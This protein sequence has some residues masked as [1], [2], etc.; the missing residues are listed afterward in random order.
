[1]AVFTKL[2]EKEIKEFISA[3]PLGN[4]DQ[5]IEILEG[6]ENTNY[7]IICN[8]IPYILTIFEKRVK[9]NDLPFFINLKF[10]LNENNFN[11]PTPI[12]DL[13]GNVI[14][15]IQNKKAVIIS[16]IEGKKLIKPNLNHCEEMGKII[17]KFHNLTLN[18]KEKR[19]NSLDI[20][21]LKRIYEKCENNN[22]NNFKEIIKDIKKEIEYV[23]KFWPTNLP[24]GIIHGDLFKDNIFFKNNK[25]SGVIDFYFSCYHFYIYDLAILINDWCFDIEE[26]N[27]NELFYREI[28]KGYNS[29]RKLQDNELSSFNILL[30]AA[31]I[32][33]L[34]TRLHD[35][36]FH[37]SDAIV[38][39][40]DPHQYYKILKWHQRNSVNDL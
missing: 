22:L 5:Y 24:S 38:V 8:D 40:K 19:G 3:Y 25:I 14:N 33:I 2:K 27:F 17:G 31:A 1:M 35:D 15:T 10:Y 29:K 4:L 34:I 7:K 6:V 36:I 16:F 9:E 11:C 37:T 23:E 12:K 18:F 20:K 32:R 28:L 21:E 30:R 13:N 39:K 26:S